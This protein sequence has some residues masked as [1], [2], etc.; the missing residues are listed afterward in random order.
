MYK[1]PL[2][3]LLF[4]LLASCESTVP[5]E[6]TISQ[7]VNPFIGTDGKGKTYPGPSWPHGMV[8]LSPDNGRNG[9]DWISGYFYPD[10]II[11]GFSH[12]HLTGTGAGDLYDISFLPTNGSEVSRKLDEINPSKTVS[13]L[14][15]HDREQ[16]SPGYYKVSLDDYSIDVELTTT[17]RTG[18]QRYTFND[19]NGVN[20][21]RLDLGYTR[22][23][24]GVTDA[25][26]YKVDK[27][28]IAGYR[29]SSG[30]A[31]NQEVYFVSKFSQE[32]STFDLF[33]NGDR[34]E[35]QRVNGKEVV[36]V[37]TFEEDEL[38]VQ[39]AI[40]SVSMEN[41]R[42]NLIGEDGNND[43]D[44][45][46]AEAKN[47]WE[48]K[49]SKAKIE[50]EE[51]V[52]ESFYTALY[53]TMLVP[54]LYSDNNGRYRG[55]KGELFASE[56]NRYSTFSLWDTY[57]ALHPWYTL[58]EK[59]ELPE[60]L[61]SILSFYEESGQLPVWSMMGTETNMM[62]GY[63]AVPVLA[64]AIEKGI[65]EP[66]DKIYTA[67]KASAM[68][69]SFGLIHYKKLG[70]V[71]IEYSS[72][73]V[74]KTM[75]YAYDD[76]CVA[77]VAKKLGKNNDYDYFM[78]RSANFESH[79]DSK[80]GFFRSKFKN[81]EMRKTFDPIA[82]EPQD[83]CE[84]NAW[85]YYFYVPHAVPRLIE[86]TGGA[87]AF[88]NKLDEMFTI[89]QVNGDDPEWISGYIGQYVHGNEPSHHIPYLY[90]YVGAS[91]SCQR[92]VRKIMDELYTTSP[93]GISGNEDCG[94]MSAWYLFSSLGFYPVNPADGKYV[95]GSPSVDSAELA[96]TGGKTLKV[97]AKN[98]SKQNVLVKSVSLNGK[99][100]DRFYV[101]H[102]E[103][104]EGGELVFE[105]GK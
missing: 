14:F 83:Y 18:A 22:N 48:T 25:M 67:M 100:L 71:P 59:E 26:M 37:M 98:Q 46:L 76:W 47:V 51:S 39:T 79:F 65:L 20:T 91:E 85:P 36:G 89:D 50:A 13:S 97:E 7:Y 64:D 24:D 105:M 53:H 66:T 99:K 101:T 6:S 75:E 90:Q 94:Q 41:A 60:I 72:W 80:T 30:W 42:Q 15:S 88:K 52:K 1:I 8:Q 2:F 81:G 45:L 56:G 74:S 55:T 38:V 104:M 29:K 61:Q 93:D 69:D 77:Q 5:K 28:T 87:E 31:R 54:S 32:I 62:I 68:Q 43:F 58:V 23:W 3:S 102:A 49:L 12:L 95:L 103:L 73:N 63:H 86:L 33:Q 84:A 16:A 92:T 19:E 57:R 10:S 78:K 44:K 11:S 82:Y 27:Y 96:L 34:V 40:S 35:V 70:Y 21:V 9:W 17:P 4:F